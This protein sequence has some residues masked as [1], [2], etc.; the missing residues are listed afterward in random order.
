MTKS[1]GENIQW[2]IRNPTDYDDVPQFF[3]LKIVRSK[4]MFEFFDLHFFLFKN[5]SLYYGNKHKMKRRVFM[6]SSTGKR[7]ME[8]EEETE[9]RSKMCS[10][11]SSGVESAGVW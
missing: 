8:G 1:N 4:S 10:Q 7:Y 9:G 2:R 5:L 6:C 11:T 3:Y